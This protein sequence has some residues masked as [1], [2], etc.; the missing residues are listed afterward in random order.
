MATVPIFGSYWMIDLAYGSVGEVE[1]LRQRYTDAG[2]F[3]AGT[4]PTSTEVSAFLD[5]VS[6]ILDGYLA[7]EG[8]STPVT[9]PAS[10]VKALDLI[11]VAYA[12]ELVDNANGAGR[13][14]DEDR[15]LGNPYLVFSKELRDWVGYMAPGWERLEAERSQSATAGIGSRETDES[16]DTVHPIF[17]REGF[18][19]SYRNWDK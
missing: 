12:T 3:D 4:I 15:N 1:A 13:F 5:S 6:S 14:N 10:V 11:A 7:V 8:F 9:S 18:G 2:S 17:Q 16:G 19:E